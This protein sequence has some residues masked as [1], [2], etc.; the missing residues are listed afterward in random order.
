MKYTLLAILWLSS[1]ITLHAADAPKRPL[2]VLFIITD[3]QRWD[4]MSCAGNAVLKTPHLDQP[5]GA[6]RAVHELLLGLSSL[7]AGAHGDPDGG[8]VS[9]PIVSSI[10]RTS[11][12]PMH[13]LFSRSIRSFCAA[14]T[15]V[16]IT[17]P[18]ISRS[19]T[20]TR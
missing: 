7:R 8:M 5:C 17:A 12:R 2:N 9:S 6:R 20:R 15:M 16:N 10:T 1:F 13:R 11:I 4:A 3:Q 19:D 14:A 18:I